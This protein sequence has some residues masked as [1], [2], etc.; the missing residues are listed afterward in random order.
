MMPNPTNIQKL[1]IKIIQISRRII[2]FRITLFISFLSST[3]M[4][5][6]SLKKKK[7]KGKRCYR[8]CRDPEEV[9]VDLLRNSHQPDQDQNAAI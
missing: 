2:K 9:A 4:E 5:A 1:N 8:C 6:L 7:K 3:G